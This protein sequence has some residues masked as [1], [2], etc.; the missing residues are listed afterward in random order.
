M[1]G[2]R[3]WAEGAR[4]SSLVRTEMEYC[5]GGRKRDG[6]CFYVGGAEKGQMGHSVKGP[7][8]AV[9]CI[10]RAL[11]LPLFTLGFLNLVTID[12][13]GQISFCGMFVSIPG[14][15]P[16]EANSTPPTCDNQRWF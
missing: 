13:L 6:V 1:R 10:W 2:E 11:S 9:D 12:V 3:H 16:L 15:Y 8:P 5:L 7:S 14:L 4:S